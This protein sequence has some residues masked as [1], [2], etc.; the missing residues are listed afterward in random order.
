MNKI[1]IL[2]LKSLFKLSAVNN[3]KNLR[4]GSTGGFLYQKSFGKDYF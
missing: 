1:A 4:S 3:K 2:N